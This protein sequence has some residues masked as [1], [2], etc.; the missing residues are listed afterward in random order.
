MAY[1]TVQRVALA[2]GLVLAM[3]LLLPKVFL[4]RGKRQEP[5]PA[6]EGKLRPAPLEP[7]ASL[8][9][10]GRTL[11]QGG[12]TPGGSGPHLHPQNGLGKAHRSGGAEPH[13]SFG[14][15][16]QRAPPRHRHLPV[17]SDLQGPGTRASMLGTL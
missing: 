14:I 8:L 17:P 6:P 9:R 7:P 16:G 11:L 12:V 15:G 2:S 5:P 13:G 10:V 1:S 4:S 3:S